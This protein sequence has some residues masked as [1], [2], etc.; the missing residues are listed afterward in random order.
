MHLYGT[1]A[2]NVLGKGYRLLAFDVNFLIE[3][4]STSAS[5]SSLLIYIDT[6]TVFVGSLK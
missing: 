6:F 2:G 1:E 3:R 5:F 4:W